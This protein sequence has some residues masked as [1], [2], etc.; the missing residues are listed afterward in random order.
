MAKRRSISF[1]ITKIS[2]MWSEFQKSINPEGYNNKIHINTSLTTFVFLCVAIL[3][4][5]NFSDILFSLG[6]IYDSN[7]PALKTATVIG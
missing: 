6:R 7:V 4:K 5:L 3:V 2:A 1:R